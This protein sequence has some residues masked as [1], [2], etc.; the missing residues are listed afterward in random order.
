MSYPLDLNLTPANYPA[1]AFDYKI[2]MSQLKC[3]KAEAKRIVQLKKHAKVV[4]SDTHQVELNTFDTGGSAFGAGTWLS[5]K[6]VDREPI[7]DRKV[8]GAIMRKLLPGHGGFELL[9][10][11]ARLTDSANQY[12][13]YAFPL[14]ALATI[15]QARFEVPI[16]STV[17]GV[18]LFAQPAAPDAEVHPLVRV[19]GVV[20]EDW[21]ELYN[22]KETL[23][24]GCEGAVY[25]DAVEGSALDAALLVLTDSRLVFPFGF[26]ERFV[27]STAQAAAMGATQRSL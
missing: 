18:T 25:F 4:R 19:R 16:R 3:S 24:P 1:W 21:R 23:V 10:R 8:L 22:L 20:L 12:H 9:P 17:A 27:V 13:V 11:P 14:A 6:Q 5:I 2:H 7:V 26:R 15:V